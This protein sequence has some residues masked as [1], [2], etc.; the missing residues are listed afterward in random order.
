[1]KINLISTKLDLDKLQEEIYHFGFLEN[2]QPYLF[3]NSSTMN[4][5]E[6]QSGS[7]TFNDFKERNRFNNSLLC[8]YQGCKV[9][10]DNSL[11][12]GEIELR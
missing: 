11:Q 1:M 6:K 5:L 12:F 10:L 2:K 7:D 4:E 9:Y 3:M 8:R